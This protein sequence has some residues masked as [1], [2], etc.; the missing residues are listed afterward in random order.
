M[1]VKARVRAYAP[2]RGQQVVTPREIGIAGDDLGHTFVEQKDVGLEPRQATFIEA[3]QHGIL[4]VGGL[5]LDRD[6]LIAKL[7]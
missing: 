2:H 1:R 5:V 7:P 6:M 4:Y 3:P